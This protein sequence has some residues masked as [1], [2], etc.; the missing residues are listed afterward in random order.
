LDAT[1]RL[2]RTEEQKKKYLPK[3]ATGELIGALLLVDR[4]RARMRRIPDTRELI[5]KARTIF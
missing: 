5:L 4:K 2:F 1:D 3:L